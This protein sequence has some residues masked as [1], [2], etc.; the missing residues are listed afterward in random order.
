LD[1]EGIGEFNRRYADRGAVA[2]DTF[3][4]KAASEG[5]I[6]EIMRRMPP[7]LQPY[8]EIPIERDPGRLIDAIGRAGGRA[9]VRTGGVTRD[10]FP[11]TAD[12]VRFL[13]RCVDADVP[14]KATA[15]LHHPL[16][17]E[18]RLT[19]AADSPSSSMF[20]FLNLFLA[21]AFLR[22]GM[23]ETDAARL[24]EEG[25]A[26]ALQ[27]DDRGV[28]WRGYRLDLKSLTEARQDG[29]ISFG[30]CS[31]TDP[32]GDLEALQLLQ[33]RAQRA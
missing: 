19:Y 11:R 20:G 8:I 26:E 7:S 9:K 2:I 32:I 33:P 23:P 18:Y 1:L 25:S 27:L 30:S 13:R 16:R 22:E 24:L 14:F 21:A 29:M 4:A 10:A 3:E 28:G 15:G 12:L 17:A 31:F 6:E 5:E